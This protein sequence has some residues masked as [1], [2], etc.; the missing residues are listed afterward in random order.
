MTCEKNESDPCLKV[1][2][3][4]TTSISNISHCSNVAQKTER[5]QQQGTL[6]K[7]VTLPQ[8]AN[9]K[10]QMMP[11][12]YQMMYLEHCIMF[13]TLFPLQFKMEHVHHQIHVYILPLSSHSVLLSHVWERPAMG[14]VNPGHISCSVRFEFMM[15]ILFFCPQVQNLTVP[16]PHVSCPL[17]PVTN[18][19]LQNNLA[20]GRRHP[21]STF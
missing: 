1:Q 16:C 10:Y 21:V 9:V 6:G 3:A 8:T 5:E 19:H 2:V 18:L 7:A 15:I 11:L 14:K 17:S 13:T 4:S 20:A 12:K